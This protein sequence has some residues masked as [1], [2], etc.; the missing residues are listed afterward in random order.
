LYAIIDVEFIASRVPVERLTSA[1][2]DF[3]A[4]LAAGGVTVMQYRPSNLPSREMLSHAR[5][6]RRVLGPT[7]S[8]LIKDRSDLCLG[9]GFDG[10]HLGQDGLSPGG[11]RAVLGKR[12]WVGISTDT[13]EQAKKA[14]LSDVD[15]MAVGG[16]SEGNHGS[17]GGLE[18]ISAVRRV[19]SKPLVVMGGVTRGNA[20]AMIEAGADAVA[21][22]EDLFVEPKRSAEEFLAI[23]V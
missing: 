18:R 12:R 5:E 8:L 6:L 16:D 21:V 20:R 10:V 14:D 23:L 7:I 22:V 9:G 2:C 17:T 19:T 15:Y 3:A 13:V 1:I 4:E 11:A